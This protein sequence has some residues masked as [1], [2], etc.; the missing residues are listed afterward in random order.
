[1]TIKPIE[2]QIL[3]H[4]TPDVAK[5]QSIESNKD[6]N[7]QAQSAQMMQ[8]KIEKDAE[9]VI[10]TEKTNKSKI[11]E[12]HEKNNSKHPSS[13]KKKKGKDEQTSSTIDVRI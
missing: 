4:S 5:Q 12:K 8:K 10:S 13:Y 3:Y 1:M 11:T 6:A 7:M 9:S 2:A